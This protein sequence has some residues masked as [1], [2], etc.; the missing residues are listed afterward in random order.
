MKKERINPLSTSNSPVAL[1][2]GLM[3][4]FAVILP[5]HNEKTLAN[6][7]TENLS[8]I[9]ER[10]QW[11][12]QIIVVDDGS[13]DKT[14]AVL[15]SM[16]VSLGIHVLRHARRNGY[17]AACWTGIQAALDLDVTYAIVMDGDGTQDPNDLQN[18]FAQS[19]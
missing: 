2:S 10:N 9:L 14:F 19:R 13:S 5:M 8:A 16:Q 3:Q 1:T 11:P 17:G 12:G 7:V 4:K 6:H 15:N 18:F